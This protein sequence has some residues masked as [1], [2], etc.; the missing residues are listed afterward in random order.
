MDCAEGNRA[1]AALAGL[2]VCRL[3]D[4]E[5]PHPKRQ[6]ALVVYGDIVLA[7]HGQPAL[8]RK[9][10]LS[11]RQ[12]GAWWQ[13]YEAGGLLAGQ[14]PPEGIVRTASR[15]AV[16]YSS[17]RRRALET[18]SAVA[19]GRPVCH[20]AVFIEAPLPPPHWPEWIKLPPRLW[21]VVSRL[22]WHLFDHHDGQE[23]RAEA[24]ARAEQA[25]DLL[26][27]RASEGGDVLVLAHGYFNHMTGRKLKA[28]GWK[29]IQNQGFKY[30]SQ[31]RYRR[32]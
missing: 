23:S 10:W 14:T 15:S 27:R 18:A 32:G 16:I 7:R 25:A 19:G 20:D 17:T 31:R 11:A 21:G 8:S 4:S 28:R 6:A 2:R 3:M 5:T 13:S 24:D 1:R 22:W 9:C 30:W 12:Y 26:I 29:L